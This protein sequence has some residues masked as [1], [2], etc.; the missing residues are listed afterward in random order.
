MKRVSLLAVS[1]IFTAIFAGAAMAQPGAAAAVASGKIAWVNSAAFESDQGLTRYVQAQKSIETEMTPRT[2]KLKGLQTQ[3]QTLQTDIAN[4]QKQADN[5][6][7]NKDAL[8][9]QIQDKND[10][11][12]ALQ[13]QFEFEQKDAQAY[14]NKRAADLLGPIQQQIGAALEAYAKQKG[15]SVILDLSALVGDGQNPGA[16]LYVDPTADVTKDF[17]SF[18]NARPA[19]TATTG[20]PQ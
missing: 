16:L 12:Q 7:A 3:M 15:Y 17:I 4:L 11:G 5:P 14:Y 6:A 13:R 8:A 18:F 9:R 2:T 19:T 10:Q 1:M 20:K